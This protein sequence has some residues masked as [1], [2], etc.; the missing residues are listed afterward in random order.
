M[1]LRLI[2]LL[3]AASGL[4]AQYTPPSG[5]GGGGGATIP[6]TTNIICG[7]GA[8]NGAQCSPTLAPGAVVPTSRTVAGKA[9]SGNITIACSDLS[10][11][12]T[13]CSTAAQTVSYS[14]VSFSTTPTFTVG[15]N[16]HIQNFQI[17]LTNNVT[18]STLT[19]TNATSGQDIAFKICQ[20]GTGSRTFVWPTNVINPGSIPTTLSTCGKQVFRYDGTNAVAFGPM[21]SDGATAGIQTASGF[22]TLPTAPAT[23]GTAG[24]GVGVHSS[25]TLSTG[26]GTYAVVGWDTNDWDTSGGALHS[27]S[28]NTGRFTANSAGHWMMIC[29]GSLSSNNAM[30]VQMRVNGTQVY[31]ITGTTGIGFNSAQTSQLLNMA[32]GDYVECLF[33]GIGGVQTISSGIAG[34]SA[35]FFKVF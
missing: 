10:N 27:T 19:T 6:S 31:G 28:V 11:G 16:T 9:L 15:A 7:D 17:T 26:N 21:V 23:L 34:N 25:V 8:G 22:L 35:Q 29:S 20:D 24:P 4:L 5:G 32:N 2:T 12:A 33:D 3:L 30:F 1:K 14:T 13:G 18:S